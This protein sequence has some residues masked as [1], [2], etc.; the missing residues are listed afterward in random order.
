MRHM[1]VVGFRYGEF[2]G[3]MWEFGQWVARD[4]SGMHAQD[5]Y[6]NRLG[7]NFFWLY[8]GLTTFNPH[9]FTNYLNRFFNQPTV[10]NHKFSGSI[11]FQ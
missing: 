5:F 8:G 9:Q 1:L 3:K 7:A 11:W 2:I 4:P 6:S 10:F